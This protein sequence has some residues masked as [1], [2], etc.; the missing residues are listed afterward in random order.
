MRRAMH[1]GSS[2]GRSAREK[3][4]K[5]RRTAEILNSSRRLGEV[6]GASLLRGRVRDDV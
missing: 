1:A 4:L 5:V 2:R 3:N 6:E